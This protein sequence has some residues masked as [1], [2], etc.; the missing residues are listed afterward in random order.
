V[1]S[2]MRGGCLLVVRGTVLRVLV[3][4]KTYYACLDP[5]VTD[6][7]K[8]HPEV[9]EPEL[10]RSGKGWRADYGELSGDP[11]FT[12][13]DRLQQYCEL[14]LS[15]GVDDFTRAEGR[16]I[17]R[18]WLRLVAEAEPNTPGY[19]LDSNGVGWY[20]HTRYWHYVRRLT[21]SNPPKPV[22]AGEGSSA[23]LWGNIARFGPFEF[24]SAERPDETWRKVETH[25]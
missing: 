12:L 9:P 7:H 10:R 11:L 17:E 14:F 5:L 25:K 15:A 3:S 6:F 2:P 20:R 18:D 19:Y 23:Q 13:L 22:P 21:H 24:V 8:D 16:A 4:G 1:R